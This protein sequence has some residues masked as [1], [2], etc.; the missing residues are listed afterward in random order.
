[1]RILGVEIAS[2]EIRWVIVEGN[3]Q[4]GK[5]T[6]LPNNKLELPKSGKDQC[7]NLIL[8]KKQVI[9]ELQQNPVD[10]VAV[11]RAD[12]GCSPVR[13]K[14]ECIVQLSAAECNVKCELVAYQT[15]AAAEKTK[16][17]KCTGSSLENAFGTPSPA[18]LRKAV[19]CAW[20]ALNEPS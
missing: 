4:A 13:A 14:I 12:D 1:M 11:V 9:A 20:T 19:I 18:Y 16:I 10:I 7:D 8:L 3:K 2:T 6:K 5:L 15:I 17:A